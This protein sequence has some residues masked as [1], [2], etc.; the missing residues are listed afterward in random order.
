[1]PAE[2]IPR[3]VAYEKV[4]R[5]D[6]AIVEFTKVLQIEP[7][8]VNATY[9]RAACQNLR[10]EFENA[11]DDY[12]RAL[13]LEQKQAPVNGIYTPTSSVRRQRS[14]KDLR[15]DEREMDRDTEEI[16]T[17]ATLVAEETSRI[18]ETNGGLP[19]GDLNVSGEGA[20]DGLQ[21][22]EREER[23]VFSSS[24]ATPATVKVKLSLDTDVIA[25]SSSPGIE[26]VA[27]SPTLHSKGGP[28]TADTNGTLTPT[29]KNR[30]VGEETSAPI[31]ENGLG[32]P[33]KWYS[34]GLK[35][36]RTENYRAAIQ[37]Y[38]QA[39]LLDPG[40]F[41][42]YFDRAFSFDKLGHTEKA[43]EDY[44]S[45]IQINTTNANSY[46]NR[47]IA[48]DKM[49]VYDKAVDDFTSAI[50]LDPTN[51]DFYHNRGFSCKKQGKYNLAL[52]DY[53][54]AIK[55]NPKYS[56]AYYNRAFVLE[57][58]GNFRGHQGLYHSA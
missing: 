57:R 6:D 30:E 20:Q 15:E 37:E 27:T 58:L 49:Q 44:S 33:D 54:E 39:I 10:G 25:S 11:I 32:T 21:V 43:V 34:R 52:E 38:T 45:A 1:M 13:Q 53:M 8:H 12:M 24:K 5:I 31:D 18:V 23:P 40:H 26:P 42:A 28:P 19:P 46:Y 17:K 14:S 36:R 2:P 47:G 9:S 3:G 7:D 50:G 48:Y 16:K 29:Q 4:G 51:A 35:S 22:P 56:R 55:R 41:R